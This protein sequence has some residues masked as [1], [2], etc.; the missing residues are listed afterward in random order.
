MG[1]WLVLKLGTL[2]YT[3]RDLQ[4]SL[5]EKEAEVAVLEKEKESKNKIIQNIN[6]GFNEKVKDLKL[7]LEVLEEFRAKKSKEDKEALKKEKKA[8]KKEK[9][10]AIKAKEQLAKKDVY[11]NNN[12]KTVDEPKIYQCNYCDYGAKSRNELEDHAL[13]KHKDRF[14]EL[15]AKFQVYNIESVKLLE[16]VPEDEYILTPEEITHLS[17][18]WKMHLEISE[19]LDQQK[20]KKL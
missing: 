17:I 14:G 15:V 5:K 11:G 1:C 18:D 16:G 3:L 4:T 12:E 2:E 19:I 10:K 20:N 6:K 8:K 13:E 7:K 9:Q